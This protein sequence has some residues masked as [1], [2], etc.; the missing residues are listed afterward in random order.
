[1]PSDASTR[2]GLVGG[3]ATE[4][5]VRGAVDDEI[6]FITSGVRLDIEGLDRQKS[7]LVE[8]GACLTAPIKGNAIVAVV[9]LHAIA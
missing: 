7:G 8:N 4:A 1:M 9:T 3:R 5:T 2:N 6:V